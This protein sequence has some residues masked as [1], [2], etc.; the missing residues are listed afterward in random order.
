MCVNAAQESVKLERY[1]V[2]YHN[3]VLFFQEKNMP[4]CEEDEEGE[5]CNGKNDDILDYNPQID[6]DYLLQDDSNCGEN[7]ESKWEINLGSINR[8]SPTTTFFQLLLTFSL[9]Y[10][11]NVHFLYVR[12]GISRMDNICVCVYLYN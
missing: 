3:G 1:S 12:H 10:S 9:K 2:L 6:L 5:D 8:V 7:P 11:H 4:G